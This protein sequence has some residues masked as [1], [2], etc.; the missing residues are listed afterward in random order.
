MVKSMTSFGRAQGEEGKGYLF[1][2]EMKSVNNRYLDINIRLPKFMIALEEEIR[3]IVNKRLSRGKV[4]I[5]INYKSY[6]KGNAIP[7][8]NVD[9]AKEYY[10]CLKKLS[11]TLE[12][13]DDITLSKIAKLPEVITLEV[14]EENI[15]EILGEIT[16]LLNIALNNM[17][18]MRIN[19]GEKLK[20]DIILKLSSIEDSVKKIETLAEE[21]P[22]QYKRKIEERIKELTSGMTIDEERVAMEVA[23]FAD[24]A[25]VD[26]EITRLYSHLN[27]MRKTL[28]LDE[29]IGRKLDFIVQEMNR[30]T[31]TIGSKCNDMDMT[32]LVI[33]IKNLIEK[34]REQVQ[35]IE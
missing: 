10:N 12:I 27:Q 7:K 26:E 6:G 1:S 21:V 25:A 24:K 33:N 13:E 5:F 31:N 22:K 20:E 30:E 29:P 14:Q 2:I 15:E 16:P 4:D 32:N 19:E 3:K 8:L 23:I 11:D 28:N 9:L 34:I 17:N 35:N 18:D